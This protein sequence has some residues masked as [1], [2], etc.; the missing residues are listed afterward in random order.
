MKIWFRFHRSNVFFED[1]Y[2]YNYYYLAQ[3]MLGAHLNL[4]KFKYE[5]KRVL[6]AF[7]LG[8]IN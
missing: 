4:N 6:F 2:Y 7:S 5:H 8:T 3:M 1:S